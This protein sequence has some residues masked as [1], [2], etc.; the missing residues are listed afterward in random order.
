MNIFKS[1]INSLGFRSKAEGENS[2]SATLSYIP[3]TGGYYDLLPKGGAINVATVFRCVDVLVGSV[4]SLPMIVEKRKGDVF[5]NDGTNILNYLLNVQPCEFINAPDFWRMIV[6][7]ILL[8]GD[9]Y[10]VPFK[11]ADGEI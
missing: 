11:D 8:S 1:F 4:S 2:S 6:Q 7:N 5:V 9:A 3:R 10:I